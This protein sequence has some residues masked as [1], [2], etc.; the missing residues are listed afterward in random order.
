MTLHSWI[1][2]LFS[3]PRTR[4]LRKAPPR[5]RL[6]VEA[7]EDRLVPSTYTVL[8]TLGDGSVGS[9]RW[10]VGQANSHPGADTIV[11]DKTVFKTPQ[12]TK[13]SGNPAGAEQ[14]DRGRKSTSQ[15][16]RRA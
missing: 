10:A 1:H 3:R 12:T 5:T 15:G 14:H 6:A 4:P 13:L 9:L 7:L 11:F 8:N 16:R 2:N